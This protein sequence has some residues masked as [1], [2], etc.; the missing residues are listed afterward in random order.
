MVSMEYQRHVRAHLSLDK[1]FAQLNLVGVDER[2][3]KRKSSHIAVLNEIAE[4][5]FRARQ[6]RETSGVDI[7]V[8]VKVAVTRLGCCKREEKNEY[9]V[10][11]DSPAHGYDPQDQG[12]RDAYTR[13]AVT[14]GVKAWPTTRRMLGCS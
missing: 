6:L 4:K 5:E 2:D 11:P 10:T 7:F 13:I 8:P 9:G 14:G 1:N 3:L 12:N